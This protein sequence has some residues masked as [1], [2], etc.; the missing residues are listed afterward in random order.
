MYSA[1][2]LAS[3]VLLIGILTATAL[4]QAVDKKALTADGPKQVTIPGIVTANRVDTAAS[5]GT[6]TPADSSSGVTYIDGKKVAAAFAKG[7]L[8][9]EWSEGAQ[10]YT[11]RLTR[12]EKRELAEVHATKTHIFY[13]LQGTATYVTGG[14]VVDPKTTTPNEIRGIAIDGGEEHRLSKG[15]VI[16]VPKG[17]PHWT[18]EVQSP[19]IAFAVNV[20]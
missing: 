17:M 5:L 7:G 4:T 20:P 15:D 18:K 2:G 12:H 8:L 14:T 16:I 11:V 13:V 6:G 19:F 10:H 1:K 9:H 3:M